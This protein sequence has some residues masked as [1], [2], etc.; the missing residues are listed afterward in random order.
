MFLL[1]MVKL[2]F[3]VTRRDCFWVGLVVVLIGVGVVYA[4]G[5]AN[6]SVMGHSAEELEINGVSIK[7]Y[8]DSADVVLQAQI[9]GFE[10]GESFAVPLVYGEHTVDDCLNA[11]G[12]PQHVLDANG[13]FCEF[14]DSSFCME[15]WTQFKDWK[16]FETKSISYVDRSYYVL[17]GNAC[18]AAR[19]QK[20]DRICR[21][22]SF[23]NTGG[24]TR[25][26]NY[27]RYGQVVCSIVKVGCY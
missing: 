25:Y 6:P 4:Y 10:G 19:G 2:E 11:G 9:D 22:T 1:S 5:S 24:S 18:G 13:I 8:I 27:D 15:G 26:C 16:E 23:S 17:N 20:S 14:E 3:E 21:G 12:V 7:D